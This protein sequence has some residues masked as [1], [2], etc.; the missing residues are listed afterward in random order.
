LL[1]IAWLQLTIFAVLINT[2]PKS[3]NIITDKKQL[4]ATLKGDN[5][6]PQILATE[7]TS[8]DKLVSIAAAIS[9][10]STFYGSTILPSIPSF[11]L[12]PIKDLGPSILLD[13]T[14]IIAN[15][16]KT[17]LETLSPIVGYMFIKHYFPERSIHFYPKFI[18]ID[19]NEYESYRALDSKEKLKTLDTQLTAL[20]EAISSD[21]ASLTKMKENITNNKARISQ[22]FTQKDTQMK[23]CNAAGH[24]ESGIFKHD[25]TPEYCTAQATSFD[26]TVDTANKEIDEKTK[27]LPLVQNQLDLYKQYKTFFTSQKKLNSVLDKNIPHELGVFKPPSTIRVLID[28][29]SSH[30]LADYFATSVHEYLH[31]ASHQDNKSFSIL[32]FEEGLTEYFARQIIK[33][34]LNISTNLGYPVFAKI[35]AQMTKAIPESDLA[36]IYFTKDQAKL[37]STIDSV[38]GEN[39]YKNNALL[40]TQ[41]QY[42]SN[43]AQILTLANTIMKHLRGAPMTAQDIFSTD[44][45]L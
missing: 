13:N 32:F 37:E 34:N 26:T 8:Y 21:S 22:T 11:L 45:H 18:V 24:Y 7:D 6:P 43:P 27:Q 42:A 12:P 44:S 10:T 40:F 33:D 31:Y 5:T 39:F 20:N 2:N 23:K 29:K 38:Y 3:L 36:D 28:V 25:Y 4:V 17:E 30:A 1:C 19:D 35:I 9:G 41:L 14:V 16:N 15:V